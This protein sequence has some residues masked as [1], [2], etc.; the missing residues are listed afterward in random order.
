MGK[1]GPSKSMFG[2][3]PELLEMKERRRLP[4]PG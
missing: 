3:A 2:K 1:E 4:G